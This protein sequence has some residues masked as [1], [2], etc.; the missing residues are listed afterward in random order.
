MTDEPRYYVKPRGNGYV[1]I[2]RTTGGPVGG[3]TSHRIVA[4]SRA[5]TYNELKH[6]EGGES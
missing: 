4:D 5:K 2:D 1:V 3:W 6:N